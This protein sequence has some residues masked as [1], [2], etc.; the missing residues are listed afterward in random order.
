MPSGHE[1]R[2]TELAEPHPMR[3]CGF[4]SP[5]SRRGRRP[6]VPP[7]PM[8]SAIPGLIVASPPGGFDPKKGVLTGFDRVLTRSRRAPEAL[9]H[10]AFLPLPGGFAP[11]DPIP[12]VCKYFE[13]HQEPEI[14][15][16]RLQVP[17]GPVVSHAQHLAV[18]RRCFPAFA[19][20]EDVVAF[21]HLQ[22]KVLLAGRA[23]ALLPFIGFPLHVL[24][25]RA[26]VA[27]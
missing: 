20:G 6:V 24:R 16:Q 14:G 26:D 27:S 23:D 5:R 3:S 18:V 22:E 9:I 7:H 21:H 25:K 11:F 19:P 8:R 13:V 12:G 4:R 15:L 17:F 1:G 2:D 10:L